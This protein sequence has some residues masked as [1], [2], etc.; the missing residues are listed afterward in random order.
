ML[1]PR[2][3]LAAACLAAAPGFAAP[4][5]SGTSQD[6]LNWDIFLKLYPK[7]ALAAKEE[8]AVGFTVSL[9]SAGEVTDCRVT[10]S[11]GHPLLDEE[12][13][14]IITLNAVFKPDPSLGPSQ[15]KSHE[16]VIAW[17]LPASDTQLAAPTAF[18]SAG[19]PDRIICKKSVKTG[20]IT[21]SERTCMTQRD[22]NRQSDDAK[23][24]WEDLQGKKGSTHGG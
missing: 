1:A 12:T 21:A 15:T 19:A 17:K 16:G 6:A 2:L 24:M 23:E 13:C 3:M 10:H 8:G 14:K 5:P 7:R 18:T 11:S 20:S 22:W 9:D 4:A